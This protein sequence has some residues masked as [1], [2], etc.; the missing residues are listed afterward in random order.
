[1]Q[2]AAGSCSGLT[3]IASTTANRISAVFRMTEKLAQQ[4]STSRERNPY[5]KNRKPAGE[6]PAGFYRCPNRVV[7]PTE[8]ERSR[9]AGRFFGRRH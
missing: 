3:S 2:E 6:K 8:L 9:P 7:C 4:S 5:L 1:M